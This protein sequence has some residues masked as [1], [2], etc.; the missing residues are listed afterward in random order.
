MVFSSTVFIFFFLPI[1]LILYYLVPF[2]FKNIILLIASLI[3]Y[4]WGEPIYI[5]L[6]ILSSF[7]DYI[8]G[9]LLSKT[10]NKNKRRLY[11]F[12]AILINLG[13][14]CFFKYSDFL[15][16]IVNQV[17]NCNI[18]LLNIG[19]PIG[20]SFYTFQTM[21]YSIDVYRGSVS[22]ETNYF[23]YLTYVSLFP[24]LVAGPIVRYSTIALELKERKINSEE[25]RDGLLRF[26]RGL[27]KKVLIANNL[28]VLY[29]TI[30]ANNV[31]ELAILTLWLGIISYAIQIYFDFSGYSDMAIGMG[32]MLGF[33][34]EENF[35]YPYLSSSIS[36]F[37]RRW[38]IS[39]GTW[40][41]DYVLYPF[42][43]SNAI[44]NLQKV[45]KERVSKNFAKNIV[46]ILGT[47]LVFFLTGLWHGANYNYVLWGLYYAFFLIIEEIGFKKVLR[48]TKVIN[49][50][51]V[52][53][54]VLLGYVLFSIE[55]LGTLS[56][57]FKGLFGINGNG[58]IDKWFIFF[59]CN[60]GLVLLIGIILSGD[61][62][63]K[64]TDKLK[65]NWIFL[66]FRYGMYVILFIISVSYI[67]SGSY[68]PFLYFRF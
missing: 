6:I 17:F 65:D 20:I 27:F 44:I 5:G 4:A 26:L 52:L 57:Y 25:F 30:M 35:N 11:L 7:I 60:Y 21:S 3:F 39:L 18:K 56:L 40:F 38:H 58:F 42:L 43:K 13:L 66:I 45:L 64:I 16:T 1:T 31:G 68:N 10:D 63:A 14:L 29:D 28:G 48:K 8:N 23:R 62:L 46:A 22:H 50:I 47:L 61:I 67:V 19:L 51:Y 32:K 15:I 2:K 49:H 59:I 24:Q 55:D 53:L 34:F 12:L 36:E 41:K 33:H 9:V 54:V 37:W